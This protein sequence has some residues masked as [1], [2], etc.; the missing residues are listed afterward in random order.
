MK[1]ITIYQP[2]ASLIMVG[3]KPYEFRPKSYLDRRA[4]LTG[5]EVGERII[6]H[7]AARTVKPAEVEDLL[8]RLGTDGD[9][10]GLEVEKARAL[11]MR[12]RDSFKYRLLVLGAALGTAVIGR[13]RN[14]GTIFTGLRTEDSDRGQFNF[15][16]PFSDIKAFPAPIPVRGQ[17]GFFE[18]DIK[19]AA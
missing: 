19:E 12:V 3:A 13:P 18:C 9:K 16:W 7:A 17:Q 8:R 5:P 11:L 10:T 4:Y 1:A 15:A 6:I 14:A 2:W